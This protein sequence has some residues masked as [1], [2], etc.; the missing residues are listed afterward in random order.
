MNEKKDEKFRDMM[1]NIIR[2]YKMTSRHFNWGFLRFAGGVLSASISVYGSW[3]SG[4][5]IDIAL[6][7]DTHVFMSYVYTLA[8]LLVL[9]TFVSYINP[10]ANHMYSLLSGKTLRRI[11]M[12]KIM[13]LPI[14]YY[15]DK[16]TGETISQI[17]NNIE[18]LQWSCGNSI[19][20]IWSYVPA[21][22]IIS[23]VVLTKINFSLLII[24]FTTI[25]VISWF[26]GKISMP[27]ADA[28]KKIQEKTGE[29]NSCLKEFIEGIHIFKAY[30]MKKQFNEKFRKKCDEVAEES[31]DIAKKKSIG[32]G[33]NSLNT[34]IP[35][36]LAYGIGSIF[37]IN[38][39]MTVGELVIF[40]NVL[41]PF[42]NSFEQ[43]TRNYQEMI[44]Q[45]GRAK[46][47]FELLDEMEERSDGADFSSEENE[48]AIEFI[49][50]SF[51]YNDA[52]S[53]LKDVSFTI[54][55]GEKIALVGISGGGKTTIHKLIC[56]F[57]NQYQGE[58]RINGREISEWNLDCLRKNIGIVSQEV[59]LFNDTIWENMKYGNISASDEEIME[60]CKKSYVD[61]I[62]SGLEKGYDTP[63][64]ERGIAMSGGQRQRI[65]IARTFLKNAPILLLDEPTSSLDTKSEHYIQEALE[66]L[67]G[68]RTVFIIA[69]RLST[70]IN[71]DRIIVLDD[72][73]I[74]E[75]GTHEE[76]MRNKR[77][78]ASLYEREIADAGKTEIEN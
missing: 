24:C 23:C 12:E 41:S 52:Q 73:V 54:K 36:I 43:I 14:A 49:N 4:K 44:R 34:L 13:R 59:F 15:E 62:A 6:S 25:P 18:Y 68:G 3:L 17:T 42:L 57:Y 37:V 7:R 71:S 45:S 65:A 30:N 48:N 38:G 53:V 2:L 78:Y 75:Q 8:A 33:L 11:S 35:N 27:I 9:R 1:K 76:L 5:M 58:I 20:G 60:A 63:V 29:Y 70:I 72:G 64:G 10:K 50:V 61:E 77:K 55:K 56:G 51:Q 26:I 39:E 31:Y 47:L 40:A 74:T 67:S 16:T 22:L 28:S 19:A 66:N 21:I 69:H 46:H 32:M